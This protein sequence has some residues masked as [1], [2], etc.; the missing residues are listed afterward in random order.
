MDPS[1]LRARIDERLKATGKGRT[2]VSEAIGKKRD[3]L[4]D[5]LNG[6]K[7]SIGAEV[8]VRLAD[9]LKCS[10]QYLADQDA[11]NPDGAGGEEVLV[12]IRG[13][14]G[15]STEGRVN[16]ASGDAPNDFA[17]IP[18]GATANSNALYVRGGSMSGIADEG[19][20]I[21]YEETRTPPTPDMLGHVVVVETE[22]GDVLVKY[23]RR[24]ERKNVYDL[25]S[26]G[27]PLLQN[28]KLKWAAHIQAVVPP[29]RARQ[30][31]RK[32][33]A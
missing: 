32:L 1:I 28:Q 16:F 19:S 23:L 17:T 30:I 8:L 25:E 31:I 11:E 26:I 20:L 12:R 29:H 5:F 13:N 15:A 18:P 14:V 3:Y 6:K 2:T 24:G 22:G 33:A 21:F 9:E 10:L 27:A 4:G 7:D